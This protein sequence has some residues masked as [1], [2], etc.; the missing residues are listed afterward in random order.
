MQCHGGAAVSRFPRTGVFATDSF[1]Q[2]IKNVSVHDL[3]HV[4]L[5]QNKH[6]EWSVPIQHVAGLL[7]CHPPVTVNFPRNTF[8]IYTLQPDPCPLRLPCSCSKFVN[9]YTKLNHFSATGASLVHEYTAHSGWQEVWFPHSRNL[10]WKSATVCSQTTGMS[11]QNWLINC[12]LT[13]P[14]GKTGKVFQNSVQNKLK[15]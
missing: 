6:E 14:R 11:V 8:T 13:K 7:F 1:L 10:S 12:T 5:F 15:L 4:T 3:V 2:V 9:L